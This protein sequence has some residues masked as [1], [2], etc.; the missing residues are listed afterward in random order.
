[1]EL[2]YLSNTLYYCTVDPTE[3]LWYKSKT[4][5]TIRFKDI[6]RPVDIF[7][8]KVTICIKYIMV[9]SSL[10]YILPCMYILIDVIH[11]YLLQS[12][13]LHTLQTHE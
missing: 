1:M 8:S 9:K 10:S 12:D 11:Q 5:Q 4:S 2:F 13:Q 6:R 7:S 3:M